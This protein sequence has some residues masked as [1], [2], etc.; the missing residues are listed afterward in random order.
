M[1]T[2][3]RCC[4]SSIAMC[5]FLSFTILG[6]PISGMA[7]IHLASP[8]NKEIADKANELAGA[9]FKTD[10]IEWLKEET[11][12]T[13][14][15]ANAV[16]NYH[17]SSFADQCRQRAR[18]VSEMKGHEWM[19]TLSLPSEEAEATLKE[20]NT[21]CRSQSLRTWTQLKKLLESNIG[22]G[23]FQ[24]GVQAIFFSMGRIE[25][26]LDVPGAEEPGSFLVDDARKIMQEFLEQIAIRSKSFV[27]SGK[28]GTV[29]VTPMVFEV[30]RGTAPVADFDLVGFI[31]PEK[32]MFS[33]KTVSDGTL[34]I[35]QFTIPFVPKG[36]FLYIAPDFGAAVG[37]VCTFS[38][39]DLGLKYPEQTVLF[40]TIPPTFTVDYTAT[41]ASEVAVP[42]DFSSDFFLVKYLCDS[43]FL[44]PATSPE[45]A[46]LHFTVTTQLSSYS[47]DSTEQ[48]VYKVVNAVA[49]TDASRKTIAEKTAL[50]LE[51]TYETNSKYSLALFFWEAAAKSFR[52]IKAMLLDI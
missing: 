15:T 40:N 45:R 8:V 28:P 13:V 48:T 10:C 44:K 38:A 29:L 52:M 50:V 41:A 27:I 4:Y 35:S 23:V 30:V 46:D 9:S 16:W 51:K 18:Q 43:C 14:D 6:R 34:S 33:G 39:S 5:V 37:N 11:G 31:P 19:L 26:T 25:K 17:L 12:T 42:K 20:Y 22:T 24:F 32:K 2:I 36:V 47:S 3:R 21:R 49:I 1:H 7:V